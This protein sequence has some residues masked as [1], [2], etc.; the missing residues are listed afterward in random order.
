MERKVWVCVFRNICRITAHRLN[1]GPVCSCPKASPQFQPFLWSHWY[2]SHS[3]TPLPA[4]RSGPIA[5][6]LLSHPLS[7]CRPEDHLLSSLTLSCGLYFSCASQNVWSLLPSFPLFRVMFYCPDQTLRSLKTGAGHA[8][9][10]FAPSSLGT[11]LS[12]FNTEV[13]TRP[14]R[15]THCSHLFF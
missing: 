14:P 3:A 4:A 13:L 1:W 12:A 8:L 11:W 15:S 10:P 9:V 2:S 5:S 7:P 6:Q